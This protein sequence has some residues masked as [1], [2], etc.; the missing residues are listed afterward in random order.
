MIRPYC[1]QIDPFTKP[2]IDIKKAKK[3]ERL[4]MQIIPETLELDKLPQLYSSFWRFNN[5]SFHISVMHR[6]LKICYLI[7]TNK[8]LIFNVYM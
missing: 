4:V 1:Y 6:L 8:W 3:K 2:F 5:S 7:H